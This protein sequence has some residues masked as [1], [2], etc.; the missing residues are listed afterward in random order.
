MKGVRKMISEKMRQLVQD[1]FLQVK[2][3]EV[4]EEVKKDPEA[5]L[6]SLLSEVSAELH[7]VRKYRYTL[8]DVIQGASFNDNVEK[9]KEELR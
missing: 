5:F 4:H 1:I 3:P 7:S 2:T 6:L 9:A 8:Y